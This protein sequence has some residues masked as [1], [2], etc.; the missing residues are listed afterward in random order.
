MGFLVKVGA[1]VTDNWSNFVKAFASF[2]VPDV[3]S[4]PELS[5]SVEDDNEL[6]EEEVT[7]VDV[8][9]VMVPDEGD[10]QDDLTQIEYE[11]PPHQR[12]AAHTL[13]LVANNDVDKF[14]PSSPLSRS[15][16]RNFFDKCT[17]LWNKAS[18]STVAS[19][20]LQEVLKRKLLVSSTTRWNTYYDAVEIVVE[21]PLA[22][23]NDLCAKLDLHDFNEREI[24]FLKEYCAVLK[25]LS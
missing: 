10:T 5:Y 13:N 14:L 8:V 17:A 25:P 21:N 20:Q 24:V 7:F 16:Y 1:T 11:L 22:D 4:V 6:E 23:L 19:D 2:A 3:F 18:R 15:I 9:E 12:C